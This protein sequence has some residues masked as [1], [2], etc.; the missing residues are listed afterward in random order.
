M[1]HGS[2]DKFL[3]ALREGPVPDWYVQ[4]VRETQRDS[5]HKHISGDLMSVLVQ[6]A[7][8]MVSVSKEPK[9]AFFCVCWKVLG[10]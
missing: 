2:L 5:Y 7:E 10:S 3:L 1:P 6:V 9:K 8:G 4:F